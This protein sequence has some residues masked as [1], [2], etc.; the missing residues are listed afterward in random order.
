MAEEHEYI[1]SKLKEA[2]SQID[3][4]TKQLNSLQGE[5]GNMGRVIGQ[6]ISTS[7]NAVTELVAANTRELHNS[8]KQNAAFMGEVELAKHLAELS[9]VQEL[10]KLLQ[11]ALDEKVRAVNSRKAEVN[12]LFALKEAEIIESYKKDIRRVGAHIYE[13]LEED[14][15][16]NIGRHYAGEETESTGLMKTLSSSINKQRRQALDTRWDNCEVVVKVLLED[17]KKLR[18]L[19]NSNS[20]PVT[21]ESREKQNVLIPFWRI[22]RKGEKDKK[23]MVPSSLVHEKGT[24]PQI[25]A[26]GCTQGSQLIQV[27]QGD[28]LLSSPGVEISGKLTEGICV[29]LK[30]L[31]EKGCD[32]EVVDV[33]VEML[34][35]NKLRISREVL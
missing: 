16:S 30:G 8:L 14:F 20:A 22:G 24:Q 21:G 2:Q 6:A 10:I 18:S 27:L 3:A 11:S 28:T 25:K 1:D 32:A 26:L 9:T 35:G 23:V 5:L 12:K 13:I 15:D 19:I 29:Q 17:R 4:V 7:G 33:L 34:K 31:A